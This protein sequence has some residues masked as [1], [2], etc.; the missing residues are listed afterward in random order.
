M[1]ELNHLENRGDGARRKDDLKIET[2]AGGPH[3][4]FKTIP[5]LLVVITGLGF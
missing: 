2:L 4:D 3:W 5:P 1:L